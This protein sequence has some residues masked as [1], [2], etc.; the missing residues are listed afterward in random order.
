M[1]ARLA[2]ICRHPI[3]S[4]G[5]EEIDR[6]ALTS[7]EVLPFDRHWAV[8]HAGAKFGD[9][10]AEWAPK[11]N[12]MRGVAGPELMAI[13]A[14]WDA[15]QG[16]MT[17]THHSAGEISLDPAT[18]SERLIAWLAPLWPDTRPAPQSLL[19]VTGQALTDMPDPYV[20]ILS[21]S[22]NR[23]LG[24]R[25]GQ[26]LSIHRWRGNL[27][28][29]GWAPFEEFDLIGRQ[30]RIGAAVLEVAQRITR[31]AATQVNP[32]TG[33]TDADTLGMLDEAY[34]HQDFGVY[35]TVVKGAD[36]ALNDPVEVV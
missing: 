18:D 16:R 22:S 3:K 15:G 23:A 25:L 32:Q 26:D 12:F 8:S 9:E 10:L 28:V 11:M 1:T 2:Q 21:L 27:W 4:I 29:E 5:Y 36:I 17:L 33:R 35:A 30:I 24:Q 20:S 6:V 7:G 34:G 19:H 13:Q 14:K 31:C